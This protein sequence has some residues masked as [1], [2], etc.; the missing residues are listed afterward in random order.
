[1]TKKINE[2]FGAEKGKNFQKN[3]FLNTK[4]LRMRFKKLGLMIASFFCLMSCFAISLQAQTRIGVIG[5]NAQRYLVNKKV[6]FE[7]LNKDDL[8]DISKLR[9]YSVLIYN[10]GR[11]NAEQLTTIRE[12]VSKGGILYWSYPWKSDIA[13]AINATGGRSPGS[14]FK[15]KAEKSHPLTTGL[16]TEK[17]ISIEHPFNFLLPNYAV[18]HV[19]SAQEKDCEVLLSVEIAKVKKDESE[20]P[21]YIPTG[22][23]KTYPWLT[24]YPYGEGMVI[25]GLHGMFRYEVNVQGHNKSVKVIDKLLMNLVSFLKEKASE[26]VANLNITSAKLFME[27]NDCNKG[28]PKPVFLNGIEIGKIPDFRTGWSEPTAIEIPVTALHAIATKNTIQIHNP[29]KDPFKLRNLYL[30]VVD[31]KGEVFRSDI[32]TDVLC[33]FQS[34][35]VHCEG[36]RAAYNGAPLPIFTLTLPTE[37]LGNIPAPKFKYDDGLTDFAKKVPV[38]W[39]GLEKATIGRNAKSTSCWMTRK[40]FLDFP[41]ETL[42][43]KLKSFNAKEIATFANNQE[44]GKLGSKEG[45]E[46]IAWLRQQ[47]FVVRIAFSRI[48]SSTSLLPGTEGY[49]AFF[50]IVKFWAPKVDIIGCD[51]WFLSPAL[52]ATEGGTVSHFTPKLLEAFCQ[53]ADIS[54]E[55]A[56]WVFKGKNR[57]SNSNDPRVL[58]AWEFCSKIQNGIMSEFVSVAKK[59]NPEVTTWVSYI[60]NNWNKLATSIDSSVSEFDEILDCQTYWYGRY[61]DDPLNAAKISNAIGL[62]KIYQSE[63]P[64]KYVWM[65][66]GPGYAGGKPRSSESTKWWK[67]NSHY[68]N[69]PEEVVPYLAT[70][71]AS[72]DGVFVWPTFNG[73]APG[74]GSDDDFADVFRLVSNLVPRVKDYVKSDIAYYYEPAATWNTVRGG[75]AWFTKREGARVSIGYLQQFCDVNVTKDVNKY[76]NVI[77]SGNLLPNVL[78]YKKQNLYFMYRPEY[79]ED[80]KKLTPAQV[81]KLGIKAFSY[82][83]TNYY[84][85]TGD[86]QMNKLLGY[87]PGAIEGADKVLRTLNV[88]KKEYVVGAQ[89]LKGNIRINS[90]LPPY[91]RQDVMRKILKE[92]LGHFKWIKR[93]CL[94]IN[95]KKDI[96]AVTF[97]EA[98]TAVVDF[99]SDVSHKKVKIVIFNGK[100]GVTRNEIISYTRGMTIELPPLNVLVATGV[101]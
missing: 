66:F 72:S 23:S 51:E 6:G 10:A 89:N 65:G 98:K 7:Q 8:H 77:I 46:K 55:D 74:H 68:D 34:G 70:L 101:E 96:V 75:D 41:K 14:C 38:D 64:N 76:Q 27:M 31:K 25:T 61:S 59:S 60:T 100:D 69:S 21:I 56:L 17:W 11:P 16:E 19:L 13:G 26:K 78:D 92:D 32:F 45:L 33:S 39:P 47:G 43:K 53:Y 63:Y 29:D 9:K 30:E 22:E 94:Q 24:V 35:W 2:T 79:A 71:C 50:E 80:G 36:M 42:A 93:D 87:S 5:G 18:T 20:N 1:M 67:H 90:F 97:R 4:L 85:L 49:N 86:I 62:G 82:V 54:T 73:N 37:K 81:A 84:Q 44:L 91:T 15:V 99:G 95:G 57:Y 3:Q 88:D 12:Y 48:R 40:D 52:M 58:K 28:Y 83:P